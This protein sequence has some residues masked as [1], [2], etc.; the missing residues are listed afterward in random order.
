[1]CE[2]V[3]ERETTILDYKKWHMTQ[4]G[5]NLLV[6]NNSRKD[7]NFRFQFIRSIQAWTENEFI[8]MN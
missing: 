2:R 5:Q 6:G 8:I 3:K 1:M 7:G 4:C